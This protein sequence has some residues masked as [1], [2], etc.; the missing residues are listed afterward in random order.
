AD[1]AQLDQ[2]E[3]RQERADQ[4]PAVGTAADERRERHLPAGGEQLLEDDADEVRD[5]EALARDG[6]GLLL[7]GFL[8]EPAERGDERVEV[9]LDRL[10]ALLAVGLGGARGETALVRA[11]GG[12][13]RGGRVLGA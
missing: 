1:L 2:L 6:D 8:Q 7:A 11:G 3:E 9:D 13:E 5:R 10:F 12:G 4:V